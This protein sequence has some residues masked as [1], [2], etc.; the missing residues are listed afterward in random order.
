MITIDL[1][2]LVSLER[3][4]KTFPERTAN[5]A[6]LAINQTA[7][8]EALSRIRQDMRKQINWKASYLNNPDK[9][10]VAKYATRGS[11]V[12]AIYARDQPTMLNRFRSNPNAMPSKTTS[13]V[14]VKVKP[15]STKVMKHAF[16]HQ[17]RKSGNIGILTR[18]KGGGAMPPSGITHGGG[19][20]IQSMRAWLL[21]APSVDQVMWDTA[22]QNQARIAKYLEVE[23]LR[24]FNRLGKL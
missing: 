19:R 11:L 3:M 24:Q 21:Y 14:K 17:F 16:V 10:G 8:R 12:A 22:K 6:R 7:K 13:G 15:A 1:E 18:T 20:Y 4:F 9:T 5:A 23:F 2:N